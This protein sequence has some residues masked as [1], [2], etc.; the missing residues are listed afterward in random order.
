MSG[1]TVEWRNTMALSQNAILWITAR[2]AEAKMILASP[3]S[4][5]SQRTIALYVLATWEVI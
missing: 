3:D 4:T 5:H 2:V 1:I